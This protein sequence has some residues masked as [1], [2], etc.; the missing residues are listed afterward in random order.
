MRVRYGKPIKV[1]S[2]LGKQNV[3]YSFPNNVLDNGYFI[4]AKS[5]NSFAYGYRDSITSQAKAFTVAS[6]HKYFA[7]TSW[8]I[9]TQIYT[10][11]HNGHRFALISDA[12]TDTGN[13]STFSATSSYGYS[14]VEPSFSGSCEV[15][16]C[17]YNQTQAS[18]DEV[19]YMI[20]I[21]LTEAF[22]SGKEPTSQE[23]YNKYNKY[24]PLIAT[25]EEITIDDKAGQVSL[26]PK[27]PVE[28]QEVEYIE[29]PDTQYINTS[30]T[31]DSTCIISFD[32]QYVSIIG[33]YNRI[34]GARNGNG[35][36]LL[37][38]RSTGLDGGNF[39]LE[40]RNTAW[41]NTAIDTNKHS[42]TMDAVSGKM[43]F[44]GIEKL[45]NFGIADNT[46]GTM[47]IFGTN[48]GGST[49]NVR[50][51]NYKLIKNG[52][53]E[54]N[55]IPCYRKSD[56]VIGMYDLVGKQFYTNQGTGIFLK[57]NDVNNTIS[58]KV[59][60]GSSDIYYGYNQQ[61]ENGQFE[62]GTDRWF[63]QNGTFSVHD[64][65]ATFTQTDLRVGFTRFTQ[66]LINPSI[67]GHK[68]FVHFYVKHNHPTTINLK[69]N[70]NHNTNT[71]DV[72]TNTWTL[73]EV[74]STS[75][76]ASNYA[77]IST[78]N[79]ELTSVCNVDIRDY[80][81]I[82][83]TDWYGT[84]K[85]P[86]TVQ[87]F[88]ERF[89]KDYYGFFPTPVRLTRYQIENEPTYGYNQ[90]VKN[91]NFVDSSVWSNTEGTTKAVS[92]NIMTLTAT[93]LSQYDFAIYQ[94]IGDLKAND[95]YMILF[96]AKTNSSSNKTINI[97]LT[98][99]YVSQSETLLPNVWNSVGKIFSYSTDKTSV[100]AYFG[101]I[102][103]LSGL[104]AN[105]DIIY[106]KNINIINLTDWYGEGSEPTTIEE[107]K[108]TFP[109]KHYPYSKKRL[110]NK[111]MINK[112][113]N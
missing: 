79:S 110:L 69:E 62:N 111:Y 39:Y 56:N 11:V 12:S 25:G 85:E 105:G 22:G 102:G 49:S 21:D 72:P 75:D 38:I 16:T 50:F 92:N 53:L 112:L 55:L 34:F 82:D 4:Y 88:K 47:W 32:F 77:T 28:Y 6:G 19:Y 59:A 104:W 65:I 98:A 9:S 52:Q 76:V 86:S 51:F 64:G 68:Y 30:K 60:G 93:S 107:F 20:I 41:T 63:M 78:R 14:L 106:F 74:I 97:Y 31:V 100:T 108:A 26:G 5:D 91:G 24:F 70:S 36:G 80:F 61:I 40:N 58:C 46:E 57:G 96:D 17:N 103:G 95:K 66:K 7:Y 2:L 87:G 8:S 109:N 37:N 45:S 73:C 35:K 23:F 67:I 90:L 1:K 27:L 33:G 113:E 44:D 89:A 18:G 13:A 29:S 101:K 94:N 99:G 48:Q 54:Q 15:G 42:I 71:F 43:T 84:G 10:N 3:S 81:V 83:L